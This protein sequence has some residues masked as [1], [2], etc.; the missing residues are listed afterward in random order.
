MNYKL[1]DIDGYVTFLLR[2]GKDF[3][4]SQMSVAVAHLIISSSDSKP[5]KS[6]MAD[7]PICVDDKWFFQGEFV[8]TT[9]KKNKGEVK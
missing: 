3:V 2:T 7:Y 1:K 5:K 9:P 6:N 4:K 8:K